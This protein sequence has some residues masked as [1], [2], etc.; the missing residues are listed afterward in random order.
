MLTGCV[1]CDVM[2]R[3]NYKMTTQ[4]LPG[5]DTRRSSTH[6]HRHCHIQ[7]AT[8]LKLWNWNTGWQLSKK[9]FRTQRN[10]LLKKTQFLFLPIY[11][12]GFLTFNVYVDVSKLRSLY[13]VIMI[14]V[15]SPIPISEGSLLSPGAM[16]LCTLK[17]VTY[18]DSLLFFRTSL[19]QF[20][21]N[22]R[23][24]DYRVYIRSL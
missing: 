18:I 17:V 11:Y 1:M 7:D 9:W 10:L 6:C 8:L 15:L 24:K 3:D 5:A 20:S 19:H 21:G 22:Y 16:C 23:L 4:P 2:Q 14:T 12:Y 13:N